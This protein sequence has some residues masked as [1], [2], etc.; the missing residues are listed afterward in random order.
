MARPT[1]NKRAAM[2]GLRQ[3]AFVDAG[4]VILDSI[5]L[6]RGRSA[7]YLGHD[8]SQRPNVTVAG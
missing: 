5:E 7:I 8:S 1:G 6:V 2:A 4:P 3:P